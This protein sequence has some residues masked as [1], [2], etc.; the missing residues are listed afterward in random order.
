MSF[1]CIAPASLHR[2][3]QQLHVHDPVAAAKLLH[4]AG[5][6]TGESLAEA[7]TA[8]ISERTGLSD[9]GQLDLRWFG[10]LLGEVASEFGWG[11]LKLSE[12]GEEALI[13]DS[14]DWA[15]ALPNTSSHPA[16]HF[17]AGALAAFLSAQA[18]TPLAVLEVEC[19]STGSERCRFAAGS[20]EILAQVWD[21]LA[22]GGD[23]REAFATAP[24]D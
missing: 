2:L 12:L 16:C 1:L 20:P 9:P 24:Q 13:L 21:L 22:A 19:R 14:P 5:F 18:G 17:T 10:P 15:E 11:S 4:E 7:W 23:W 8:R 6:A 3:R